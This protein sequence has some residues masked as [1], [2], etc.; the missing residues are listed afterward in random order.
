MQSGASGA[1]RACRAHRPRSAVRR[2]QRNSLV[3]A[4]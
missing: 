2:H 3:H 1:C 4:R